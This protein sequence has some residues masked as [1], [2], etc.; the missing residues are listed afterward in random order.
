VPASQGL[1]PKKKENQAPLRKEKRQFAALHP[2]EEEKEGGIRSSS[3]EKPTPRWK[4]KKGGKKKIC[5][6]EGKKVGR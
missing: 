3:A 5:R 4:E 1:S 2:R 6:R